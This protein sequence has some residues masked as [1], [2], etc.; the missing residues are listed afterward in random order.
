LNTSAK[1]YSKGLALSIFLSCIGLLYWYGPNINHPGIRFNESGDG[2]KNYYTVEYHVLYDSTAWHFQ[3]MNYPYGDN[4]VFTDDQP[5][6]ANFLRFLQQHQIIDLKGRV[7]TLMNLFMLSGIA[8]CAFFLCLVFFE[9]SVPWW[10]AAICAAA[11]SFLSPQLPRFNGHYALAYSFYIPLIWFLWIRYFKRPALWVSFSI[12][13][14]IILASFVHL[15]YLPIA[16]L[17][18]G[19]AWIFYYFRY[20]PNPSSLVLNAFIQLILP[21]LIV[22]LWLGLTDHITDRPSHPYGFT[23]Y[24][25]FYEGVFLPVGMQI[26]NFISLHIKQIRPLKFE[27]YSYVGLAAD[28][29]MFVVLFRFF[30]QMFT[31]KWKNVLP[32]NNRLLN[33]FFVA[34]FIVLLI[35]LGIPFLIH[36]QWLDYMGPLQQFRSFGRF[37]WVFF[38]VLNVCAFVWYFNL[39]QAKRTKPL[40]ILYILIPLFL[41]VYDDFQFPRLPVPDIQAVANK[42]TILPKINPASF[43]A[44]L[45]LPYFFYGGEGVGFDDS[46]DNVEAAEELSLKTGLPLIASN[47]SRTSTSEALKNVAFARDDS[48]PLK[49]LADYKNRKPILITTTE[50]CS[51]TPREKHWISMGSFLSG[52]GTTKYYSFSTD[53]IE[54][55]N[56]HEERFRLTLKK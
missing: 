23:D 4:V 48:M 10:Y 51:L 54:S 31:W 9:F 43:Q 35:S 39:W 49:V 37:A 1:T 29:F 30:K 6:I 50:N 17:F 46:C 41:I 18:G 45:P 7:I 38:Y 55:F 15:Y 8:V 20:R 16:L 42:K 22:K 28:L 11:I 33:L 36:P 5:I 34:G 47:M 44:I 3:G 19:L 25:A 14:I 32:T 53:S 52:S 2:L 21:L 27:N 12:A 13:I 40:A 24:R 26:G 56:R